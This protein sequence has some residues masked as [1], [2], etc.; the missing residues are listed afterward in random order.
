MR[1]AG[2]AAPAGQLN[3]TNAASNDSRSEFVSYR[4][5]LSSMTT[6][7]YLGACRMLPGR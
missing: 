1:A 3:L 5:L 4:Q 7:S 6:N 2:R